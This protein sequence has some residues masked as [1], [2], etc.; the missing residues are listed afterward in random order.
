MAVQT[1]PR[2]TIV[3]LVRLKALTD[4][5]YAIALTLLVLEIRIP[6]NTLVG[7]LPNTLVELAPRVLIYLISFFVIGGAWG[8][9]QR[10]FSQIRRGDG[11][12]VWFNFL[13][14]LFVTL[15]PASA[16]LVGR[17]PAEFIAIA[18]FAADVVLIQL[19]ALWLWRHAGK[20]GLLHPSLDPRVV[21]AV[22]HRLILIGVFFGL[23]VALVLV[24]TILVY[25][26]WIGLFVLVFTTDWLSWRQVIK[27]TRVAI[28]LD[29][30]ARGLIEILHPAGQLTM[31]SNAPDGALVEG[32]CSGNVDSHISREGQCLKTRL[33][34][35]TGRGIL[36]WRYTWAWEMPAFDWNLRVS[37][38]I[39]L[40]VQ[41]RK[42]AG[43]L[44]L[45]FTQSCLTDFRLE[46]GNSA[47]VVR[48]PAAAG[49]T[50][51]HIEAGT[52]SLAIHIPSGV[53]ARINAYTIQASLE[54]DVI[55][56]PV[57]E[58]PGAYCS[59]DYEGATHRAE[60]D[61]KMGVGL[62]SIT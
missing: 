39:P 32:A 57:M 23:S 35:D 6:E 56:F 14:L 1:G 50:V 2:E 59:R 29:A 48:L 26:G 37:P 51:V 61:L 46:T 52:G 24:N 25:V 9:H 36:S 53:A 43:E 41:I 30:A 3:D 22:G 60:I 20:H 11:L 18:C 15:V 5:V 54:V 55:R 12:L 27:T 40:T 16:A 44:D 31:L 10:M 42:G 49:Q 34:A 62:V 33:A 47:I 4:G 45:D 28:P 38:R 21:P 58:E 7:E 17:F 8:S 13:S 19:S